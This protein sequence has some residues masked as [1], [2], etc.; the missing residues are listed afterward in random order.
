[1]SCL[2]EDTAGA[3]TSRS[4]IVRAE[5]GPRPAAVQAHFPAIDPMFMARDAGIGPQASGQCRGDVGETGIAGQQD[6]GP[7]VP[8]RAHQDH[9]GAFA[10]G[11]KVAQRE[12]RLGGVFGQQACDCRRHVFGERGFANE[13]AHQFASRGLEQEQ[14]LGRV[15][16][17]CHDGPSDLN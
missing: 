1:M 15:G 17:R 5:L 3:D 4:S 2:A 12:P 6:A 16:E 8:A 10:A 11:A 14:Q 9:A 7:D 13:G